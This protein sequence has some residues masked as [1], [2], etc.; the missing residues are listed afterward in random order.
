MHYLRLKLSVLHHSDMLWA[1][2]P[3]YCRPFTDIK[4]ILCAFKS[5]C[6][7]LSKLQVWSASST[8]IQVT[9]YSLPDVRANLRAKTGR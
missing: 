2:F 4:L 6:I 8:A 3:T 7:V 5:S 1:L 9:V